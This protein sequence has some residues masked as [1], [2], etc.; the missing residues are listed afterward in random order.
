MQNACPLSFP[1]IHGTRR[2][3][4]L[5]LSY[6]CPVTI[7]LSSLP[8]MTPSLHAFPH[9]THTHTPGVLGVGTTMWH[10]L[11]WPGGLA[12]TALTGSEKE[13]RTQSLITCMTSCPIQTCR[14]TPPSLFQRLLISLE[15][16]RHSC[17]RTEIS[18]WLS[19]SLII[20]KMEPCVCPW[21]V[22]TFRLKCLSLQPSYLPWLRFLA[23]GALSVWGTSLLSF[24]NSPSQPRSLNPWPWIAQKDAVQEIDIQLSSAP[25]SQL[26]VYLL[27]L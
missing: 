7:Q 16:T 12:D 25:G 8:S 18:H 14:F 13:N 26:P 27:L 4:F 3:E 15:G 11:P 24:L 10:A 19:T 23:A 6:T 5:L 2:Q 21:S 1:G 22:L 17:T 20:G 9:H